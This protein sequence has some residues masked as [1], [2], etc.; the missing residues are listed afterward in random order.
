MI[1]PPLFLKNTWVQPPGAY[2]HAVWCSEVNPGT[3]K[4]RSASAGH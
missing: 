3:S 4:P 1:F 2:R